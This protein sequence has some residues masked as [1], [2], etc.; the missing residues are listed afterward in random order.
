MMGHGVQPRAPVHL[1]FWLLYLREPLRSEQVTRR[2]GR[3][4][5]AA[6][7]RRASKCT[8]HCWTNTKTLRLILTSEPLTLLLLMF[9]A[10]H[11]VLRP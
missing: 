5:V 4:C 6:L 10:G 8:R 7:L 1:S 11:Q 2:A 9:C 3:T